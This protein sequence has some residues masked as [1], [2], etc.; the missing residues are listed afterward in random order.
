[1]VVEFDIETQE[2]NVREMNDLEY[3]QHLIDL[4]EVQKQNEKQMELNA[5]S[6]SKAEVKR[7]ALEALG[8]SEEII[9]LLVE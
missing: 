4:E 5:I 1:M 9:N 8:L 3:T 2:E 6:A 7:Q